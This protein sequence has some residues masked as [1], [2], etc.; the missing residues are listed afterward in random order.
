[1]TSSRGQGL[2]VS[3]C[4]KLLL[5]STVGRLEFM[6]A[7]MLTGSAGCVLWTVGG[8]TWEGPVEGRSAG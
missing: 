2:A 3:V 5:E 7:R 1:M 4:F 6:L 8:Q